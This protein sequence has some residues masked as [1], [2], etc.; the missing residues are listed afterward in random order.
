M[1]DNDLRK[2][3]IEG[4]YTGG[5]DL[6]TNIEINTKNLEESKAL[7]HDISVIEAFSIS[8]QTYL[9]EVS[10]EICSAHDLDDQKEDFGLDEVKLK[11]KFENMKCSE[12]YKLDYDEMSSF[13]H[14]ISE[15]EGRDAVKGGS[16]TVKVII[17]LVKKLYLEFL[18][19]SSNGDEIHN[20]ILAKL[21]IK[22]NRS[23]YVSANI[24]IYYV[25]RGCG[26][27]NETK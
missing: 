11:S 22:N 4:N 5:D 21:M 26:I 19:T 3:S 9:A 15:L 6:S 1:V 17:S 20:K 23:T 27:F 8:A 25:V 10:E 16:N 12:T 2:V 14:V 18:A 24:F 7:L 13:F